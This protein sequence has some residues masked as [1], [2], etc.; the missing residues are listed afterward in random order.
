MRIAT[1]AGESASRIV[2]SVAARHLEAVMAAATAV[3]VPA[4]EIGRVGGDRIRISVDGQP[5]I[6]TAVAAAETAWATAIDK[7]MAG[8]RNPL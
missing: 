6:D 8:N 3:G 4:R 1:V 7:K 5:A 2:V